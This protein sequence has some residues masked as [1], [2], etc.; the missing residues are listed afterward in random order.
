MSLFKAREWWHAQPGQAEEFDGG[1]LCIANI[2]ND[3]SGAGTSLEAICGPSLS[4]LPP[5]ALRTPTRTRHRVTRS[6]D[7][8]GL[9]SRK[10]ADLPASRAG[11]P[12]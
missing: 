5:A 1:C 2:D 11:L 4:L 9:V 3:P 8:D 7:R 12:R 6:E 10:P